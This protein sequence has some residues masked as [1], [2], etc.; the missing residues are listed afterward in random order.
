MELDAIKN[1]GLVDQFVHNH[2]P[3]DIMKFCNMFHDNDGSHKNIK[4]VS[5]VKNIVKAK[6]SHTIVQDEMEILPTQTSCLPRLQNYLI[7][8]SRLDRYSRNI[9]LVCLTK[10][11]CKTCDIDIQKMSMLR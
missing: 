10:V 5:S 9:L 2:N 11:R 4:D 6:W 1:A 8:V 7:D 3:N